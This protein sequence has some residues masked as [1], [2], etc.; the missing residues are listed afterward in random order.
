MKPERFAELES[1][2]R[3]CREAEAALEDARAKRDAV[4]LRSIR[5]GD[6]LRSI[7]RV[8]GLSAG[9]VQRIRDRAER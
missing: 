3:K 7:A 6:G 1:S 5:E 9:S 2:A 8:T 4:V